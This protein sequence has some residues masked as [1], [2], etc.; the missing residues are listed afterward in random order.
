VPDDRDVLRPKLAPLNVRAQS[1]APAEQFDDYTG[2]L[3]LGSE[4]LRQARAKR[5]TDERIGRLEDK[6]DALSAD[7]TKVREGVG[8]IEGRL[9]GQD[10]VLADIRDALHEHRKVTFKAFSAEMDVSTAERKAEIADGLDAKRNRRKRATKLVT[11][12][13]GLVGS[14]AV[15][16]ELI[17]YLAG[18]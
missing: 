4:E 11:T 6:H 17:H 14:G 2:R 1:A 12:A 7:V 13:I 10:Q 18:R 9:D 5:P 15:I 3:E 16:A 8:R